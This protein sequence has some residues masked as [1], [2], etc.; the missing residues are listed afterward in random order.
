MYNLLRLV[1]DAL[2][3]ICLAIVIGSLPAP[4]NVLNA[5]V[6]PVTSTPPFSPNNLG[7]Q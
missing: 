4:A 5:A 7:W 2:V 1:R 3:G 6:L